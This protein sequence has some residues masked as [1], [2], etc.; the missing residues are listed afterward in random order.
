[1]FRSIPVE[2]GN[3]WGAAGMS[4][5]ACRLFA[6]LATLLLPV[7]AVAQVPPSE[8]PGRERDRFVEPPQ[9]RAQPS[10][11]VI[12]LPSTTAPP[13]AESIRLTI[14]KVIVTG[15]TVYPDAEFAPL[16][17]DMLGGEVTLSAVYDLARRIT[18]KYGAAGYVLSRAI[19]PP[20]NFSPRGAVVR[21]QVVEGYVDNVVWPAEKLARYR[22]FFSDYTARIVADRPANIRTLERYLL[23]AN[24]LP[25]LKFST[26]L[27][28]SPTNP[29]ASTLIV[30][31]AEKRID[32]VARIDNRGTEARG[33]WQYLGSASVNNIFGVH[34][35]FT[36][37][38]AG[39]FQLEELQYFAASYR[40]VLNSEGLTGFVNASY[41][42]GRPG[43]DVLQQLM[44]RTRSTVVEAGLSYPVIRTREKNLTVTGLGFMTD[45]EA[46]GLSPTLDRLRGFRLKADADWADSFLGINQVNFTFSQGINGL[47]STGNLGP[48]DTPPSTGVGRVDFNKIEGTFIRTQP[49]PQN[50]SAFFAAYAQYAFTPLLVSEQ[51]SYGGRFFGRAFDPSQMLGDHCWSVLGEAR[52][53]ISTG[54]KQLTRS[55]LYAFADH[56]QVYYIDPAAGTPATQ[57][58]TSAGGGVRV[59]WEDRYSADL[60]VAKALEGPRNDWRA[61]LVLGAKY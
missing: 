24:D 28:P 16:Y 35:Q 20:Q 4:A 25:G 1:M 2:W 39:T 18:A 8:Q 31:V 19:V 26:S 59:G 10:A 57:H 40:Q 55:Q 6:V 23:L 51:C 32:G 21:I 37:T 3:E 13:G 17:A 15:A 54:I 11:G 29:N 49:L 30:E 36:A 48:G 50:F 5:G 33:P 41:G 9:A 52:Y 38:W 53:D 61:F 42:F 58:G 47:G 45:D 60:Q 43:T 46:L 44:Y 34:E 12:S 56:G 27:K 14:S 22:D 7:T